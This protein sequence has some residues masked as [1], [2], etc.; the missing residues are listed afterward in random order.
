M[1]ALVILGASGF[2]G[3]TVLASPY[4]PMPIKAVSRKAPS[5]AN[6]DHGKI[7]WL[8]ADLS[9]PSALDDVLEPG[10]V[11]VNLAY[12]SNA[13]DA[14]NLSL[15]DNIVQ[16]CLRRRAARLVHCSTAVVAGAAGLSRVLE[17]TPCCP[18]TPYARIKFALEQRVLDATR[19][20]LDVGIL[21][22]TAIV[23]PGGQNLVK[24]ARS[25]QS[26][27]A[28]VNYLRASLLA[29]RP[30][31]LVPV[32][33]VAAAVLHLAGLPAPLGGNVY[34]VSSDD[35]PDN[36]FRSV[37]WTLSVSL[38]LKPRSLQPLPVPA[39]VLLPLLKAMGRRE[40]DAGASYDSQKLLATHFKPV[41]TVLDAVREFGESLR[42]RTAEAAI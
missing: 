40:M 23:G 27:P 25:L 17:T 24:L 15:I 8:E 14:V 38:G 10:D 36:N 32:R 20:G 13:G 9:A 41:D 4:F 1:P 7:T 29:R 6:Y 30:M 5:D 31:H 21:R 11:V 28:I 26:G 12:M 3:R 2:L 37:E 16:A 18:L 33:N 22:P 19:R 42:D 34:H 39:S 35:D